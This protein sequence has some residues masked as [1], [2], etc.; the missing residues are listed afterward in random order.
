M[1]FLACFFLAWTMVTSPAA[2]QDR[3]LLHSEG[4][5]AAAIEVFVARPDAPGPWPVILFVHGHQF[6]DRPGGR[7]FARPIAGPDPSAVG[8]S[9]LQRMGARGYLAGAVSQPGYGGTSGPPDY[10]GPATQAAIHR[11]LD[12]LLANA[13]ADPTRVVVFGVSRGAIAASMAATSDPRITAL[14][15]VAGFYDLGAAYPTG[16][17]GLDANIAHEAGATPDAFAARS[18]LRHADRIRAATLILHGEQ[19]TRGGSVDQARR[20]AA[21]LQANGTPVRLHLHAD[22]GHRIPIADV[23]REA[24]P[25]LMDVIGR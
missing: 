18:A 23:W 15:L 24:D 4:D 10:C 19:D 22:T 2:G 8:P 20:L 16:D 21:A 14:I 9:R 3:V 12:H 6:P 17:P 25:F 7:V 11:A 13:D 5:G 1:R